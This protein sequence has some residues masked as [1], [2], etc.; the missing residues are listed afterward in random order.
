M[1]RFLGISIIILI[2]V[3]SYSQEGL[4]DGVVTFKAAE[5]VYVRFGD[6]DGIAIGDTLTFNQGGI[7]KPCLVVTQKSSSSCV[8]T[9]I[10][11]CDI[12]K[13]DKIFFSRVVKEEVQEEDTPEEI[14]PQDLE[15]IISDTPDKSEDE[16]LAEKEEDDID[17]SKRQRIRARLSAAT[18]SN[19]DLEDNDDRH[20]VMGRF[21][22]NAHRINN[23]NFHFESYLNYRRNIDQ[24]AESN[25]ISNTFF[26]IYNL[27]LTYQVDS[28]YSISVGRKINRKISSIGPVDGLQAEK[29]FGNFYVGGV[30]GFKPDF[31]ELSFDT[32]LFEFGGYFGHSVRT[33]GLY[34]QATMGLLEQR[35]AGAIDRRY[36]YFQYSGTIN[37][38]NLF[39]SIE[40]DIYDKVN[41]VTSSNPRLTNLYVSARYRF[42]RKFSLMLS[43]DSRRRIIYYETLRTEVERLLADDEA[44]QGIRARINFRP[45]KYI[46]AGA[47]YSK[48]YQISGDN[49]SDNYNFHINH[50]KLPLVGGR[51]SFT[52]NSNATNTLGSNIY[53]VRYNRSIIDRK[54]D[55]MFYFRNVNY[56]YNG[57]DLTNKINYLG[58]NLSLRI[59]KDLRLSLLGEIS[60]RENS[61]L[62]RINTKLIKRFDTR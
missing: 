4:K 54:L 20:R 10:D 36:A 56:N 39:S 53:S 41:N 7:L 48:R 9:T 32:D 21:S 40:L 59:Q 60:I 24:N 1:K 55:G 45:F 16:K 8:C 18:Y 22:M 44:R 31:T 42:S 28:S 33:R 37:D 57:S 46:N 14:L 51:L 15:N 25:G 29:F 58:V 30:V 52:Y 62:G 17:E 2:S 6:T 19:L 50:S 3:V 5:N 27:A 38:L 11:D 35:N 43:Y 34:S 49:A 26:N 12:N 61:N 13:D 23:S 47:S